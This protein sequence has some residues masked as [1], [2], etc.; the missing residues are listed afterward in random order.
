MCGLYFADLVAHLDDESAW[1]KLESSWPFCLD[2]DVL[3]E[4]HNEE[5]SPASCGWVFESAF[6]RPINNRDL[7]TFETS[8]KPRI[9]LLTSSLMK[10]IVH[11]RKAAISLVKKMSLWCVE[12]GSKW[13]FWLAEALCVRWAG[14][15]LSPTFLIDA[16]YA[17]MVLHQITHGFTMCP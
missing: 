12:H 4:V 8:L 2:M 16:I 15:S 9:K 10:P 5:E 1:T 7:H 14:W 17:A 3:V 11:H 13:I 6:N